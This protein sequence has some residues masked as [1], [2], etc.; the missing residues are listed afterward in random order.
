[1]ATL[2]CVEAPHTPEDNNQTSLW[3]FP[4]TLIILVAV[5]WI[6]SEFSISDPNIGQCI[7]I[8]VFLELINMEEVIAFV[9][10]NIWIVL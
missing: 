10:P 9:H 4:N 2:L 8:K 3:A 1:M 6:C 7:L 5:F